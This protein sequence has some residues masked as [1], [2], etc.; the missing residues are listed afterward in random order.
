MFLFTKQKKRHK[1][2]EQMCG[3]QGGKEGWDELG[4]GD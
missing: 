1:C 2:R 4:G 3:H